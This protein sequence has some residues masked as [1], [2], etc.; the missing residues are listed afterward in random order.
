MKRSCERCP[1]VQE[2]P[3]SVEDI[4]SGKFKSNAKESAPKYKVE[5]EGKVVVA[6]RYLCAACEATVKSAI[7]GVAKTLEKKASQ[8]AK[9]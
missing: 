6:Y 7:E 1:A 8:R 9:K 5:V 4:A 3:I 2:I